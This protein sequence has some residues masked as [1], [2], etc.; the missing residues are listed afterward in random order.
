MLKRIQ[1]FISLI[2]ALAT[3]VYCIV[4]D[5]SLRETALPL[6]V[7]IVVFYFAGLIVRRFLTKKVFVPEEAPAEEVSEGEE[8]FEVA[9]ETMSGEEEDEEEEEP[10]EES[11]EDILGF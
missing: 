11:E 1:I 3:V 8:V 2:A 4:T 9:E 5:M 7:V 6:I 10:E